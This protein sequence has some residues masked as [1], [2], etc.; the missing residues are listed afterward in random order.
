MVPAGMY[1]YS[2]CGREVKVA[3]LYSDSYG[4]LIISQYCLWK[5]VGMRLLNTCVLLHTVLAIILYVLM[6]RDM[7]LYTIL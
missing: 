2:Y 1:L 4:T 6:G 7:Y 3:T 5:G